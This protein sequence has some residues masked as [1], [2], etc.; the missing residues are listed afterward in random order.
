MLS[1]RLNR[2]LA[3]QG[4][5]DLLRTIHAVHADRSPDCMP[6]WASCTHMMLPSPKHA[7]ADVKHRRL[8]IT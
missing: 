3:V 1:W 6:V 4:A 2:G 7:R 5:H 8:H